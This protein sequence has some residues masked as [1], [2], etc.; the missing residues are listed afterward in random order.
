[1]AESEPQ[2]PVW[3]AVEFEYKA[4]WA[5]A[6]SYVEVNRDTC[7]PL[8]WQL[9]ANNSISSPI[10]KNSE[11]K[12]LT[13]TPEDGRLVQRSRYSGGNNERFK[14]YDYLPQHIA[15]ERRD[16]GEAPNQ[17][18]EEWPLSNRVSI[19]YP[20]TAGDTVITDSYALLLLAGRF[21]KS[22]EK[23]FDVIVQTDFNFYRV[24]MN[25][26]IDTRVE[27][28]YQIDGG[29][30]VT[31]MR[32]TSAVTMLVEPLGDLHEESDFDLLG[33][34]GRL[35]LFFDKENGVPVQLRGTAPRIGDTQID[36]K[37]VV[38]RDKRQ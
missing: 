11:L 7:N 36:L 33:L 12:Q 9:T 30:R 10:A 20:A 2:L 27:V 14:F 23:Y 22:S 6:H 35:I 16:P 3:R 26:S 5:T 8:R 17:P 28:N 13:L 1:M 19:K 4:F 21:N 34:H 25:H 38:L 24:R 32:P 29:R 37:K 31:G 15:R 18:P